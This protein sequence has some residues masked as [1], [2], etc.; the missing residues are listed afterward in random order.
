MT[1]I[2]SMAPVIGPGVKVLILGSMPG[3][4]SLEKQQYY[5]NKRN[6]FWPIISNLLNKDIS[7]WDYEDK[8]TFLI[9]NQIALWDVLASC[10]RKG[11]L[12]SAIRQEEMNNLHALIQEFPTIQWI[13][14]NGTKA[15]QSFQK[16]LKGTESLSIPY[17]KLPSSSPVP[18]K[19]VKTYDEKVISWHVVHHYLNLTGENY[20]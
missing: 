12:D 5:G 16:Y 2:S 19:N 17:T 4:K 13:G 10:E 6:H 20:I 1:T 11:S 18:G 3:I 7:E 8:C 14:L 9:D 15:Y